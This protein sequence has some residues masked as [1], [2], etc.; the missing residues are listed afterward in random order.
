MARDRAMEARR[1]IAEGEDPITKKQ[2]AKPKTFR[3][4]ALELIASKRPG[5]KNA[6][7]AA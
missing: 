5:W 4:A 1:L 6:K 7:H 2:Q 3:E